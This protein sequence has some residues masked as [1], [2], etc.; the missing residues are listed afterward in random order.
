MGLVAVSQAAERQVR[1]QTQ[2]SEPDW[3]V[4]AERRIR[5]K[6]RVRPRPTAT[7]LPSRKTPVAD[8][9][10]LVNSFLP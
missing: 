3:R 9:A 1:E 4:E 7:I 8:A 5:R 10:D 2:A 6:M